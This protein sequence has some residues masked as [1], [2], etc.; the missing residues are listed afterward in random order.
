MKLLAASYSRAHHGLSKLA[1]A[2]AVF[3]VKPFGIREGEKKKVKRRNV[4]LHHSRVG[5]GQELQN[6]EKNTS[7]ALSFVGNS[8]VTLAEPLWDSTC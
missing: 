2:Q 7:L 8:L 3:G 4:I 1:H 5:S 6:G